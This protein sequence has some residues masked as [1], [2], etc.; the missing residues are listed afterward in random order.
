MDSDTCTIKLKARNTTKSTLHPRG[1]LTA[2]KDHTALFYM[3][4]FR[5]A[6][7]IPDLR[8]EFLAASP[9]MFQGEE[10]CLFVCLFVCYFVALSLCRF[11]CFG[12]CS[13]NLFRLN[14]LSDAIKIYFFLYLAY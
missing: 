3:T 9:P 5:T 2:I 8:S 12:L 1:N 13:L 6:S 7:C 4:I 11:V 14:A 10:G